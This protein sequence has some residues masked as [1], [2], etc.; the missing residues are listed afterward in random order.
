LT[1][2]LE[3]SKQKQYQ[4]NSGI[5][6]LREKQKIKELLNFRHY[7]GARNAYSKKEN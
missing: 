3:G 4:S 6:N 1:V 5:K 2:Y 7:Y